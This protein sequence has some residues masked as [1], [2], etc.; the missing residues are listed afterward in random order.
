MYFRLNS[1]ATAESL[2]NKIYVSDNSNPPEINWDAVGPILQKH[3]A[4]LQRLH[5][6]NQMTNAVV[7]RIR[8]VTHINEALL[9]KYLFYY[10]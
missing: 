2:I 7:K 4:D 1:Y 10:V 3:V 9:S 6:L 8:N 5:N